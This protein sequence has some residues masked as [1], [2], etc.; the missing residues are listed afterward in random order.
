LQAGSSRS[1]ALEICVSG[2]KLYVLVHADDSYAKGFV[3][4][5]VPARL[6]LS[7]KHAAK[8]L[9]AAMRAFE[10]GDSLR[11]FELEVLR[12]LALKR[13]VRDVLELL[14]KAGG[15]LCYVEAFEEEPREKPRAPCQPSGEKAAELLAEALGSPKLKQYLASEKALV[16]MIELTLLGKWPE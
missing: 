10:A 6:L 16:S 15:A 12:R 7:E 1:E 9:E 13:Q 4:V 11:N 14:K 5:A 2:R 8:A 3:R